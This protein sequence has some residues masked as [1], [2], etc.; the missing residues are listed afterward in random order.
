[1]DMLR[2]DACETAGL[3]L[4]RLCEHREPLDARTARTL[5]SFLVSRCGAVDERHV[6]E[7]ALV[8][9][10][11]AA[12]QLV[13]FF[14]RTDPEFQARAPSNAFEGLSVGA[15]AK[16]LKLDRHLAEGPEEHA[17]TAL[18]LIALL[19]NHFSKFA[20]WRLYVRKQAHEQGGTTVL[21]PA[22]LRAAE[23]DN[24]TF[25]VVSARC[26]AFRSA[27]SSP[28]QALASFTSRAVA[29]G[30]VEFAHN[31]RTC[32]PRYS[33]YAAHGALV[34]RVARAAVRFLSPPSIAVNIASVARGQSVQLGPL[35]LVAWDL[36]SSDAEL[37]Y[38]VEAAQG[39]SLVVAGKSALTFTQADVFAG[40]VS[41]VH[42]G[43]C[44]APSYA[45]TVT[46]G[47]F[48]SPT[49]TAAVTAVLDDC[50]S[51]R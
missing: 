10:A 43:S 17:R 9:K 42:D 11:K 20:N 15:I 33:V 14:L 12:L 34:S 16:R 32:V 41:L 21:T 31:G 37:V 47:T 28:G 48:T 49:S 4:A 26:G 6:V 2:L 35:S 7:Q 51:S 38:R 40:S 39:C 8:P 36:D 46:D 22:D 13:Y 3:N 50:S 23:T 25:F 19:S 5:V 44:T 1:M 18:Q 30:D 45:L 27:K 24:A 29:D